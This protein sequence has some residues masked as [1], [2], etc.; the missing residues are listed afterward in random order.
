M[1]LAR[2]G[3][4]TSGEASCGFTQT[5]SITSLL[6]WAARV[7]ADLESQMISLMRITEL[8]NTEL[9]N[10]EAS[11]SESFSQLRTMTEEITSEILDPGHY[12]SSSS[13]EDSSA[14]AS[15]PNFN[16]ELIKSGWPWKGGISF[17]NVSMRYNTESSLVLRI[18]T[19]PVPPGSTL[20]RI[21]ICQTTETELI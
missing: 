14:M 21:F 5:L 13:L 1:I 10:P 20:V 12:F 9:T 15:V 11:N 18:V 2:E 3:K 8:V 19:V 17:R 4:L 7:L 16:N 6:A